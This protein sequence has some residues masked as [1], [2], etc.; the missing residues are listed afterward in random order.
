MESQLT[1]W[2]RILERHGFT[3]A[4]TPQ[5]QEPWLRQVCAVYDKVRARGYRHMEAVA[6]VVDGLARSVWE[7]EAKRGERPVDG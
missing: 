7:S 2:R 3:L 4:G 5:E 1:Q 6:I